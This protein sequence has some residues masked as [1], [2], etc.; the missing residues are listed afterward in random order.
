MGST[1]VLNRVPLTYPE[2]GVGAT[3]GIHSRPTAIVALPSGHH[4][5]YEEFGDPHGLPFL[6]F[7]DGG[8]SRL[9]CAFLHTSAQAHGYRLIAPDRPGIGCSSYYSNA[10][11]Q[12]IAHDTLQLADK[13]NLAKFGVISQGA[14]GI[15]ALALAHAC[16]DRVHGFISLAG[17]PGSVFSESSAGSELIQWLGLGVPSLVKLAVRFRFALFTEE[18][19]ASFK[20]LLQQLPQAD[21]SVLKEPNVRQALERDQREMM[22]QGCRGLAQDLS[23]CFRKLDFSLADVTVPTSIWQGR[24][25]C[26][27][28]RSD[29]EFMAS[30][31]PAASYH[32][33]SN[34]GHFFFIHSIDSVFSRLR[35]RSRAEAALAA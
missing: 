28:Q 14:G 2:S 5:A 13:L 32:R 7:H 30:H 26:L 21:R 6:Y 1:S 8:S 11:A 29:C 9:E 19:G 15:F 10:T 27:S 4:V 24:S 23:N 34:G 35:G 25:D 22:R 3:Q 20:R 12:E 17:V 18:P 31:M 16:P 33:V